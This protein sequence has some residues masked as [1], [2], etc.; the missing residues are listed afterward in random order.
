MNTRKKGASLVHKVHFF[1]Q[2]KGRENSPSM[3]FSTENIIW[4]KE[5]YLFLDEKWRQL[6]VDTLSRVAIKRRGVPTK[7]AAQ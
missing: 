2:K 5:V 4:E 6:K 3:T 1:S 7:E